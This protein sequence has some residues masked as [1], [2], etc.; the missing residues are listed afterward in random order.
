MAF[1]GISLVGLSS[2]AKNSET[3][4][5]AAFA[6][7]RNVSVCMLSLRMASDN[8]PLL[9]PILRATSDNDTLCS[10][11]TFGI[12]MMFYIMCVQIYFVSCTYPNFY[13][14]KSHFNKTFLKI[15]LTTSSEYA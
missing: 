12:C 1:C 7:L 13:R 6:I 4:H 2:S 8:V 5:P 14:E 10:L 9:I 15:C 3:L 11:K